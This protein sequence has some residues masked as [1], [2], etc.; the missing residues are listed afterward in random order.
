MDRYFNWC[1]APVRPKVQEYGA[2]VRR[3]TPGDAVFLAGNEASVWIPALAGRRVLLIGAARPPADYAERKQVE[4]VMLTSRDPALILAA[5][6]RYG[7]GYVAI[8]APLQKEYGEEALAGLGRLPV[9]EPVYASSAVRI[10][11]LRA[12]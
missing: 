11:K 9:Y 2:W 7:I 12:D 8:D 10:L 3:N 5:A 1:L 4:R 6:R